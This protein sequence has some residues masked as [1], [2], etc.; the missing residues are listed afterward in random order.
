MKRKKDP[1][2][3]QHTS[4]FT[5]DELLVYST[6]GLPK[7][8][9]ADIF[10]HLNV[11]RCRRCRDLFLLLGQ[12]EAGPEPTALREKIIEQLKTARTVVR[13]YPTPLKIQR[14]QIWTTSAR[15]KNAKGETLPS[16]GVSP[17]VLVVSGGNGEK[18]ADN[19]IRVMPISFDTE[20]ELAGETLLLDRSNPLTYPV[21]LEIFNE[22][23]MLAGNLDE[24]RGS[25]SPD[26]LE[27]IIQARVQFLGGKGAKPDEEFLAWKEKEIEL[28]KFLSFP[29]N[30]VLW[31]EEA[32]DQIIEIS[33][34]A[35]RKAADVSEEE[36]SD[37]DSHVL[38]KTGKFFLGIVQIRDRF[39]LRFVTEERTE[40][41]PSGILVDAMPVLLEQRGPGIHEALLGY[42]GHMPETM[43]IEAEIDGDHHAFHIHFTQMTE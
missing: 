31:E 26:E 36:L 9:R 37:I 1:A 2:S 15:P 13:K 10:R 32:R 33:P 40:G 39:L 28:T 35:Y 34:R 4:C 11:E 21:L 18:V 42:V 22:R 3:F 43:E 8:K 12:G 16:V 24:Y 17:P 6:G 38:L 29:V 23:P 5:G 20:Y 41:L 14:G 25:V 30:E 7:A 27:R 19:V